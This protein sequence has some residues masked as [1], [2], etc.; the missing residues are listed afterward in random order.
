[1]NFPGDC[2]F[3]AD[4]LTGGNFGSPSPSKTEKGLELLT[5]ILY[6]SHARDGRACSVPNQ[7][8]VVVR[9]TSA[10]DRVGVAP[11]RG[12]GICTM[13]GFIRSD[14]RSSNV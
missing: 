7:I 1:M 11:L 4:W 8:C 2:H 5:P 9:E 3:C 13:S 6:H 14:Y 10:S 12:K